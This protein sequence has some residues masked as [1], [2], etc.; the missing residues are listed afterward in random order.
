LPEKNAK[1]V[2]GVPLVERSVL[3]AR[4]AGA[5]LIVVTTDDERVR[6]ALSSQSGLVMV[7]RPRELASSTASTDEVIHHVIDTLPIEPEATILILQ[8]TS[9]FRDRSLLSACTASALD[10]PDAVTM[11]VMR[12]A[13]VAAWARCMEI[14]GNLADMPLSCDPVS[15]SGAVYAFRCDSFKAHGAL[16]S[17]RKV[18]V[19][20]DPIHSC[21][22]DEEYELVIAVALAEAGFGDDVVDSK[23]LSGPVSR[24]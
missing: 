9:P 11:S 23:T 24:Q 10:N 16:G 20:S 8:P 4:A 7:D 17:M 12:A 21:D 14:D 19:L 5:A 1:L 15:P 13:K 6:S 18:G 3:H 22:I 2:G